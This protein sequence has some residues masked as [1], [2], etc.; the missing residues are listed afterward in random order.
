MMTVNSRYR[1]CIA[2]RDEQG[3]LVLDE[4]EPVRYQKLKDNIYHK[5]VDG[6]TLWG[7]AFRYFR[8]FTRPEGLWWVIAEFQPEPILDPTLRLETGTTIIVPSNR[9]LK[10]VV[11]SED[12]RRYH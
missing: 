8:E 3:R 9:F 6:D 5:V 10:T 4:R 2:F 7:L 12:Q 1:Y 11:F